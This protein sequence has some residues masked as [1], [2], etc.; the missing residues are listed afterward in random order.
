MATKKQTK[1]SSYMLPYVGKDGKAKK[2]KVQ[3]KNYV[4]PSITWLSSGEPMITHLEVPGG[5]NYL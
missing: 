5:M 4:W 2:V 3:T 1:E